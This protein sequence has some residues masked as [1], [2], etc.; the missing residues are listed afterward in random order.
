M[1]MK[2]LT[3]FQAVKKRMDWLTQR[4]EVLSHNIANADSPHFKAR[5]L[6]PYNFKELLRRESAQLN[7]I[8][9]GEGHLAGRRK[10]IRDFAEQKDL[11]PFETAPG[12]N[13]VVLE[14]Q[15]GKIGE[16]GASYKMAT[17]LYRKH[18]GML[19]MAI[20]NNR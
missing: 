15:M 17:N 4:Q 9:S 16:T 5:D 11:R 2:N 3:I 6:K 8:A 14:E 12:G 7:I 18:I 20:G 19:R 10:R 13:S 1:D